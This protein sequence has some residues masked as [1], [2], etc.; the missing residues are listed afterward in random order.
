MDRVKNYHRN[1]IPWSIPPA[2]LLYKWWDLER[3]FSQLRI[4]ISPEILMFSGFVL[5][6]TLAL[7]LLIATKLSMGKALMV[8]AYARRGLHTPEVPRKSSELPHFFALDLAESFSDEVIYRAFMLFYLSAF[9]PI[10]L[11]ASVAITI[12]AFSEMYRGHKGV[13]RALALGAI[14]MAFLILSHSIWLPI[15]FQLGWRAA[16]LILISKQLK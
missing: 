6:I 13:I 14:S 5:V 1:L 8:S 3:P 16:R 11:A 10:W 4:D 12:F 7:S 2:L 9:L 15:A